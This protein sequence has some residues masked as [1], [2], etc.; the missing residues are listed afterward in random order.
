[1]IKLF[2][3]VNI[4]FSIMQLGYSS[5]GLQVDFFHLKIR[6]NLAN[7][8]VEQIWKFSFCIFLYQ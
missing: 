8:S 2:K 5:S 7:G 6:M 4:Y 1:M 3:I